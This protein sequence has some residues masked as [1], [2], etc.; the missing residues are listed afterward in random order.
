[1]RGFGMTTNNLRE[2]PHSAKLPIDHTPTYNLSLSHP[3][4][5]TCPDFSCISVFRMAPKATPDAID[6]PQSQWPAN[7]SVPRTVV[8][9]ISHAVDGTRQSGK[10]RPDQIEDAVSTLLATIPDL[11][12]AAARRLVE[13]LMP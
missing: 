13:T 4:G 12:P 1:M 7:S 9:I 8:E 10:V 11:P 2:F 3:T 5:K 6:G